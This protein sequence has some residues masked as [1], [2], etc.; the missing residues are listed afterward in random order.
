MY[1]Y[2]RLMISYF[3]LLIWLKIKGRTN[4]A[5][6]FMIC[7]LLVVGVSCINKFGVHSWSN[8]LLVVLLLPMS[9]FMTMFQILMLLLTWRFYG[10]FLVRKMMLEKLGIQRSSNKRRKKGEVWIV[11][12]FNFNPKTLTSFYTLKNF[13][14]KVRQIQYY[15]FFI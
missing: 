10:S 7:V 3:M 15:I 8:H 9:L 1:N 11:T 12:L 6:D 4:I 5:I 14:V 2:Y 13:L